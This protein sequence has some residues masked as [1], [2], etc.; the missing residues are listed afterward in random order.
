MTPRDTFAE[1]SCA[2]CT[3]KLSSSATALGVWKFRTGVTN[4]EAPFCLQE[5]CDI[6]R[7]DEASPLCHL[8]PL[9]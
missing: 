5:L 9:R 8:R 3:A 6:K 2:R 1:R 7:E 4:R